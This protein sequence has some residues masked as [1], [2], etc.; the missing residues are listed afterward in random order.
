SSVH[1]S[2]KLAVLSSRHPSARFVKPFHGILRLI[3]PSRRPSRRLAMRNTLLALAAAT[4][5]TAATLAAPSPAEAGGCIGCAV[6]AGI[7]GG[8]IAGAIL[9]SAAAAPPR[10]SSAAPGPS[11]GRAPPASPP[12]RGFG[13]P[14][15]GGFR[16]GP[17]VLVSPYRLGPGRAAPG[18]AVRPRR[19]RAAPPVPGQGAALPRCAADPG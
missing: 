16:P 14:F 19:A 3:G 8:F 2:V 9:G 10:P 18:P 4:S 7:A 13:A 17:R 15:G 1:I 12:P 5:I 6:G 11:S